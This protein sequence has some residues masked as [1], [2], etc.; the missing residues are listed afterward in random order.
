MNAGSDSIGGKLRVLRKGPVA[1]LI[2]DNQKKRNAITAEMWEQF[3]PALGELAADP[4]VKVV[5]FRGAGEHFS[6]GAD[7]AA[8]QEILL[9]PVGIGDGGLVTAA[10]RAIADFPKPTVA[11][12]QGNCVGGAWQIA[13]A[14]DI[15]IASDTAVFAI[16]PAKIGILYPLSG[17][18]RLVQLV[19][20]STAKYLL[21]SGDFVDAQHA[22]A[23]GLVARVFPE[24]TFFSDIST[25]TQRL[26]V[27]SQL[28]VRAAKDLIDT[29]SAGTPGLTPRNEFW[30]QELAAST[31]SAVGIYAFLNKETPQFGWTSPQTLEPP[32]L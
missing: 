27:R 16:T 18:Q 29:I 4:T 28:S 31:E 1:T 13:G 11:A 14:C 5:I 24:S 20:A 19:G 10:E 26:A 6:S 7:I 25:F 2:L 8:L 21:F 30:K 17:I 12:I 15:R 22:L 3:A 9:N 32:G 23:L